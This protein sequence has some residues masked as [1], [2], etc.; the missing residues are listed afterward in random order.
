[1]RQSVLHRPADLHV[2][3]ARRNILLKIEYNGLDFAGWQIQSGHRT[4][5][6][7]LQDN[8][9]KFLRHDVKLIGSGRTD[10][11]VHALAQYANFTTLTAISP[12]DI[13][14][15]LNRMLPRDIVVLACSQV[16][17][18]FDARRQALHRSYRYLICERLSALNLGFAWIMGRRLDL[19]AL[20]S[21]ASMILNARHFD[22]FCKAKSRKAENACIIQN[23]EWS[24]RGGLLRFDITANRF[25]HNMVRLLVGTMVAV[26]DGRMETARFRDLLENRIDDKTRFIAPAAGLYLVDVEYERGNL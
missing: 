23:A 16:P 7:V 1:M 17:L 25:L 15:R 5:Q 9:R 8:L 6:G 14:Y 22:N 10:S 13:K 4:V 24:R 20:S 21:L 11:G 12:N 18:S 26:V 19:A 2:A 3:G